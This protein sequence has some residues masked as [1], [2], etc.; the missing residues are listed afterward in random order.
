MSSMGTQPSP[1]AT[2]GPQATGMPNEIYDLVSVVYHS[3]KS[4]LAYQ[5]YIQD[6]QQSGDNNLVQ[7]FQNCQ[8][9]ER[10]R[11]QQAQQILQQKLSGVRH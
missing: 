5:Q 7:F 4:G 9:A 11:V 8:Q 3:L 2:M 1:G 6:A 10:Q